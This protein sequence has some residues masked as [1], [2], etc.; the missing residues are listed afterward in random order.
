MLSEIRNFAERHRPN[1]VALMRQQ[2]LEPVDGSD[3]LRVQQQR[4]D[5]VR[6]L[7][8]QAEKVRDEASNDDF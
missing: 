4:R 1:P 8:E 5:V 7:V 6:E 3:K 2:L